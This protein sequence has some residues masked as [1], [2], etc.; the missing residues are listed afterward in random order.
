L[1]DHAYLLGSR[2]MTLRLRDVTD[3]ERAEV[4]RITRS[5]KLGAALVRRA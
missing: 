1:K 5:H 3:E 2:A 4:E